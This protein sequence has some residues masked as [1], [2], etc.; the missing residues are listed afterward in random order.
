MFEL[1]HSSKTGG[2][3]QASPAA[4]LF[5]SASHLSIPG[6][7]SCALSL[8][9]AAS[10]GCRLGWADAPVHVKPLKGRATLMVAFAL[11]QI[12]CASPRGDGR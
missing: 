2:S 6:R 10:L 5:L 12:D 1:P 8:C 3:I 7:Q 11:Q 9:N 4:L